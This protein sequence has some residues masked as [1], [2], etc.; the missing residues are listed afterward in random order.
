VEKIASPVLKT[1]SRS[2]PVPPIIVSTAANEVVDTRAAAECTVWS[3]RL[4]GG[5]RLMSLTKR[6]RSFVRT[7]VNKVFAKLVLRLFPAVDDM[8]DDD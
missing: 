3:G 2:P 8:D 6:F 7:A 4:R 1:A 5:R